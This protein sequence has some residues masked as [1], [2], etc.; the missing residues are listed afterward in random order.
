MLQLISVDSRDFA[1]PELS[2]GWS[3]LHEIKNDKFYISGV[4]KT[5]KNG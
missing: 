4:E 3:D 2:L 1:R 5:C